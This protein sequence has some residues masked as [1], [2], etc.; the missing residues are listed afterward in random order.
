MIK[1]YNLTYLICTFVLIASCSNDEK[2]DLQNTYNEFIPKVLCEDKEL[3]LCW[4]ASKKN[5]EIAVSAAIKQCISVESKF[6]LE[7]KEKG[8]KLIDPAC[9]TN[10]FLESLEVDSDTAQK[11]DEIAAS[12]GMS[13]ADIKDLFDSQ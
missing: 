11:C 10:R 5:C 4:E 1:I 12:K 13:S 6:V 3:L 2:S 9:I 7:A 8:V